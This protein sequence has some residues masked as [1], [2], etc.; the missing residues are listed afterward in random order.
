VQRELARNEAAGLAT[1][2]RVSTRL[3]PLEHLVENDVPIP[4]TTPGESGKSSGSA[5]RDIGG[6][7]HVRSVR[8]ETCLG[9][10]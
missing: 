1:A 3:M 7:L 6:I 10:L 2:T 5:T 4:S 8:Q 9:L